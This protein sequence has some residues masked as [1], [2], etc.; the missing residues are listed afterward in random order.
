MGKK[1]ALSSAAN[2][3]QKPYHGKL[4]SESQPLLPQSEDLSV[5]NKSRHAP[6]DPRLRCENPVSGDV[7]RRMIE[8]RLPP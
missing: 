2:K 3:R 1:E 5:A 4:F 8:Q 6:S 7:G